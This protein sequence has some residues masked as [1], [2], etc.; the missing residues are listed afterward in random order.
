M[1]RISTGQ[2]G[3]TIL[4][5]LVTEDNTVRPLATTDSL[6]L[7]GNTVEVDVAFEITGGNSL[8]VY[9]GSNYVDVNAPG[10]SSNVN[11]T[12]PDSTGSTGDVLR[13]DGAG[14]LSFVDVAF[15]VNNQTADTAAYYPLMS[16]SS[17]GE[18]T[19]VST[20]TSKLSFQPSSGTLSVDNVDIDGGNIDGTTIGSNIPAAGTFTSITETSSLI[21]KEDVQPI[22]NA[23][24]IVSRHRDVSGEISCG[25]GASNRFA[26]YSFGECI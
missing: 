10:L 12:L 14:N 24:D 9:S 16:T 11:F 23:I 6:S 7:T 2:V 8:R 3:D 26:S 25:Q 5:T 22:H 4:G 1:R 13:S 20:S 17:S 18:I 21:Y 19:G 15:D